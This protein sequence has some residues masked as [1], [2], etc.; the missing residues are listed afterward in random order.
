[1]E[2]RGWTPASRAVLSAAAMACGA[3]G[4]VV[5]YAI[6]ND[7][8]HPSGE[9]YF[10]D[11]RAMLLAIGVYATLAWIF[12]VLPVAAFANPRYR[13]LHWPLSVPFG[14]IY[15]VAAF[16]VLIG[17]TG[18]WRYPMF[19]GEA[20]LVGGIAGLIYGIGV[21]VPRAGEARS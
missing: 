17:W 9:V 1:M 16:M 13:F 5:F 21:L 19:L 3:L 20:G 6:F 15:G 11:T 14:A 18:L 8:T 10:D 4:G 7:L 12:F 2:E